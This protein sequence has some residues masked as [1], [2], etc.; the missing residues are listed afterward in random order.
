MLDNLLGLV[1][2]EVNQIIANGARIDELTAQ[3]LRT[4]KSGTWRARK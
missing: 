1:F 4:E 2:D 3:K